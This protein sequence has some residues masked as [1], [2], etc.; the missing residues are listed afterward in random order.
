MVWWLSKVSRLSRPR[1]PT[2]IPALQ[3]KKPK[4]KEKFCNEDFFFFF[5]RKSDKVII[6]VV[7]MWFADVF[8]KN[9][10]FVYGVD[11]IRINFFFLLIIW[12]CPVISRFQVCSVECIY[13]R[14][15][16]NYN[17]FWDFLFEKISEEEGKYLYIFFKHFRPKCVNRYSL[18]VSATEYAIFSILISNVL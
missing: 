14:I 16:V 9:F 18:R 10:C 12:G 11:L 2:P 5:L 4:E 15:I 6:V 17:N 7:G 8:L 1:P 3:K 13:I